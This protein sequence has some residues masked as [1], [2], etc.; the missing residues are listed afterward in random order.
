MGR[1]VRA[2]AGGTFAVY[3]P[4]TGDI[5]TEVADAGGQDALRAL[6]AASRAQSD[7]A[8]TTPRARSA[9]LR[10]AWEILMD[11]RGRGRGQ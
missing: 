5:L 2:S 4:A 1:R 3:N 6:D 9:I 8:A 7:W 11:R 10:R